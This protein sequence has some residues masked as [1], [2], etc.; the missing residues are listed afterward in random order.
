MSK[1]KHSLGR[2]IFDTFVTQPVKQLGGGVLDESFHQVFGMPRGSICS[3][4]K[5]KRTKKKGR[6]LKWG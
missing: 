5:R 4:N 1:R 2:Q 6:C 3:C